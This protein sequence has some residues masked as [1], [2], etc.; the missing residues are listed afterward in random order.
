MENFFDPIT[1]ETFFISTFFTKSKDGLIF[2]TDKNGNKIEVYHNKTA[3]DVEFH[4][5]D[6][7]KSHGYLKKINSNAFGL[8]LDE[9]QV[10]GKYSL[11]AYVDSRDRTWSWKNNKWIM[12]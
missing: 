2:H 9:D 11:A 7:R 12:D 8:Y 4:Y 1:K 3:G 6:G 10:V 5:G